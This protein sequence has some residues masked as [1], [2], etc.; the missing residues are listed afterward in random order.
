M[1][2]A[3]RHLPAPDHGRQ[4]FQLT[5]PTDLSLVGEAVE[6]VVDCCRGQ[7]ALSSRLRF[8]LRTVTAEALANAMSYGNGNDA[9]RRVT[10]DIELDD[11]RIVLAVSDEGGGFDPETVAELRDDEHHDATGGR[12]LFMIR[13]LAEQVSFNARGNTIWMTLTRH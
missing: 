11:E 5:V 7:G 1:G 6:A 12:G 8:R 2:F 10:V 9:T 3:V 4:R 13:R